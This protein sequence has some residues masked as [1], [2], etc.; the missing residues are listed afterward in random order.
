MVWVKTRGADHAPGGIVDVGIGAIV[1]EVATRIPSIR[2]DTE[3]GKLHAGETVRRVAGVEMDAGGVG[4]H[5]AVAH[6]VVGVAVDV[7]GIRSSQCGCPSQGSG[8]NEQLRK[9]IPT[10]A[11]RQV[12]LENFV[13]AG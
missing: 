10:C 13:L 12:P 8:G 3:I 5:R 2:L 7:G 11:R 4:H 6:R 9:S 1:Q